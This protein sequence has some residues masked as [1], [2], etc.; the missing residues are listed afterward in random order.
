MRMEQLYDYNGDVSMSGVAIGI[1]G[2]FKDPEHRLVLYYL[3]NKN[4]RV[5]EDKLAEATRLSPQRIRLI[6]SN[7]QQKHLA[8]FEEGYG[9][10][11]TEKG[12]A[13]LYNF[14]T[15]LNTI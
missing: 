10:T 5:E 7:L 6:L 11:L 14:H 15:T 3:A 4:P 9:Y 8:A 12:L 1:M 13:T 2:I